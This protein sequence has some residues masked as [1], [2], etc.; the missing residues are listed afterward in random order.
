V[1]LNETRAT[2]CQGLAFLGL[3]N[4][5]GPRK[6]IS[7]GFDDNRAAEEFQRWAEMDAVSRVHFR[8]QL[9][10]PVD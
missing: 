10:G 9:V 8:V 3:Q 1:P 2:T 6:E 5:S 7:A 4:Y